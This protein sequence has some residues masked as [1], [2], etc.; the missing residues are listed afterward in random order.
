M[1]KEAAIIAFNIGDYIL[2][3]CRTPKMTKPELRWQGPYVIVTTWTVL[4]YTVNLAGSTFEADPRYSLEYHASRICLFADSSLDAT[5]TLIECTVHDLTFYDAEKIVAWRHSDL[6]EYSLEFQ[7]KWLGFPSSE[8]TWE[9]EER[10]VADQR[11]MVKIIFA[12]C[13]AETQ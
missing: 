12:R 8:N 9:S 4:V 13:A 3:E 10:L 11:Q 7:V 6:E 2:V 5:E 1:K